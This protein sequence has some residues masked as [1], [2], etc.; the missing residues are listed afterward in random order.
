M[1]K[2]EVVIAR[3]RARQ[4]LRSAPATARVMRQEAGLTQQD[5]AEALGVTRVAVFYWENGRRLPAGRMAVRYLALL[6]EAC[7]VVR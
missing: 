7:G 2:A 4:Q 3:A 1:T 5:V 6:R